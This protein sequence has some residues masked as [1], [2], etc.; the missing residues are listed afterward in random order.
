[1]TKSGSNQFHGNAQ[2][3]WNGR[4]LNVNNWFNKAAGNE[5]PFDIANQWAGSF[6]GPVRKHTL[7][8]F[9]DTEGLRVFV[10]QINKVQIP[11]PQ[12]EDATIKNIDSRF[13]S[14]SASHTFYKRLFDLYN[15]APGA[16]SASAG[17]FDPNDLGCLAFSI[18]GPGVPCAMHF[19]QG[20]SSPSQ[21]ALTAGRVDWNLNGSDRIFFRAHASEPFD[22]PPA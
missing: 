12:F 20:R 11:S 7:F 16:R 9:F 4:A 8:F 5:R 21:D 6:G 17:T 13:G 18:L 2:Y 14:T 19:T 22:T 15:A 3:Y 1:M 10:P